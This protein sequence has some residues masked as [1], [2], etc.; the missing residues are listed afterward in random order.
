[1]IIERANP[2]QIDQVLSVLNASV[3]RLRERGITQWQNG[4]EC[5]QDRFLR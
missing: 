3:D 4:F 2:S 1:M 5:R